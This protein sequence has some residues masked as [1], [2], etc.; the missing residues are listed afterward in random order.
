ML[1]ERIGEA[2]LVAASYAV[3]GGARSL[4]VESLAAAAELLRR[5]GAGYLDIGDRAS[6]EI[7]A[8]YLSQVHE[9]LG[10]IDSAERVL[11]PFV[12]GARSPESAGAIL[13]PDDHRGRACRAVGTATA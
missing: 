7:N 8:W 1:A 13:A 6:A 3:E 9:D 11:L 2:W 4:T 10:D 5:A 12:D